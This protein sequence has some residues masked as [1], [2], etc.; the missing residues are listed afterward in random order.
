MQEPPRPN[1]KLDSIFQIVALPKILRSQDAAVSRKARN[2]EAA[3]QTMARGPGTEPR[4]ESEVELRDESPLL[5]TARTDDG[6]R[7]TFRNDEIRDWHDNIRLDYGYAMTIASAKGL[8][9]D[10]AF[11]LVDDRPTRE[12]IYPAATRQREGIDVYV[13]RSPLA[14]DITERRLEDQ[15]DMP[16][17]DSDVR[18]YLTERWSRSQPKEAALDNVS[19]GI[20]RDER[21]DAQHRQRGAGETR[22]G[23]AGDRAA[24]N[25]SAL[26]LIAQDI[27]HAVNDWRFGATVDAFAAGRSEVIAAWDDL[28]ARLEEIVGQRRG[29]LAG[30]RPPARR[31]TPLAALRDHFPA[32]AT[33]TSGRGSCAP[34]RSG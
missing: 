14:I 8:T 31:G 17:T 22:Q 1:A 10:R 5:I 9:V 11:L 23:T 16:V 29:A 21:E 3:R 32:R 25:D 12:T 33:S 13:N 30:A 28:R 24:A 19:D 27:R 26:V 7:V 4:D 34:G 6:R 15:A 18:A 20:W 2:R